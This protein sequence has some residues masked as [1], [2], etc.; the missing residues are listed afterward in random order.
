MSTKYRGFASIGLIAPKNEVNIGGCLRAAG[1]Y[2]A[3][4]VVIEGKAL[5]HGRIS[6]TDTRNTHRNIPVIY[7]DDILSSIPYDSKVIAVELTPDAENLVNFVHPQSAFYLF[8]PEGGS[9]PSNLLEV[10]DYVVKI[11]T[12]SCLNLAMCCNVVLYD[13]LAKSER[14]G[15]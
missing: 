4:C 13:R 14:S 11:P 1:C 3:K 2:D 8:G 15:L 7:T 6:R 9:I 5:G 12:H 10:A